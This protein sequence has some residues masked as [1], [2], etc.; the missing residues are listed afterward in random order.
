MA[1]NADRPL[2]IGIVGCGEGTHGEV[3]AEMLASPAGKRF[4]M[5]PARV[6]DDH[7]EVAAALAK[8]TGAQAVTSPRLAGED[9]DGVLITEL[10][11]DRYLKLSLP[12]LEAGKRVFYNRPFAG[13][14][15]D[16]VR[17]PDAAER[18]G[19]RVYSASALYHTAAGEKAR[20]ELGAL[21]QVRLFNMTGPTDH[22]RFYLPHAIAALVSVLGTG[23]VKVQAVSLHPSTEHPNP[24]T[25]PVVI[26]VE[27][28][29]E[30]A[31]GPARGV[32]EMV[33]P[34]ATWYSFVMK[35][36]GTKAES[37]EVHFEVSYDRLLQQMAAFF[38][39]GIEPV[40]RDVLL[41]KTAVYYAALESSRKGGRPIDPR[42]LIRN[43]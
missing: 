30:A 18:H 14:V 5:A 21:G 12:F 17:I 31:R 10:Y 42:L 26:Y 24:A 2:R 25:A 41:E 34:G 28:G 33:G 36:Y 32:I 9:V 23:I 15:R 16:A 3:W 11:P 39:T 8:T 37:G 20:G 1:G 13:S 27:Y 43:P 22:I 19:A 35:L 7:P 38:R 40:S 6:W 4:G 29:R